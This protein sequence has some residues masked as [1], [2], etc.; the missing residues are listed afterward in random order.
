MQVFAEMQ[1][2]MVPETLLVE[3]TCSDEHRTECCLTCFALS[4][5]FQ[6]LAA[7]KEIQAQ[8]TVLVGMTCS[9][10]DHDVLNKELAAWGKEN[11]V[12]ISAAFDGMMM[13][14]DEWARPAGII[15]SLCA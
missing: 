2:I 15:T 4:F 10:G 1:E 7:T 13:L 3:V 6:V 9:A 5:Q 11:G 8:K 12:D 14:H